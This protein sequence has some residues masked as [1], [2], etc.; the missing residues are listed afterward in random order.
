MSMAGRC[1]VQRPIPSSRP[2]NEAPVMP[3]KW[4]ASP[5][6]SCKDAATRQVRAMPSTIDQISIRRPDDW[7]VHLRDGAMMAAVLPLTARQFARAIVMP[8]LVPPVM[9]IADAIAYRQRIVDALPPPPF[10]PSQVGES[11]GGRFTPL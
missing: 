2:L 10:P 4:P 7:H 6:F 11:Q 3:C 1:P 5:R 8:N 9:T